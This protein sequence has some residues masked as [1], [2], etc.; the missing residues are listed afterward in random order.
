MS[1]GAGDFCKDIVPAPTNAGAPPC[2]RV[3]FS[4]MR[5]SPKNLQGL[6]PLESPGA[7]SPP[8][9]RSLRIAP[10]YLLPLTQTDLPL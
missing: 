1:A 5:K 7:K 8:F 9:S 10:G 3:T 4:P 2:T 6:C